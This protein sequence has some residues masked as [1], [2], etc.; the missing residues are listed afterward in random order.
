MISPYHDLPPGAFWRSGVAEAGEP[1]AGSLWPGPVL[2]AGAPIFT[3]GDRLAGALHRGL[4]AAGDRAIEAEPPP[5][6]VPAEVLRAYGWGQ[7]S[8]RTGPLRSPRELAEILGEI[9]G[10]RAPGDVIRTL[11]SGRAADLRRP[12]VEPAGFDSA[13]EA[14]EARTQHLAAIAEGLSGAAA[15]VLCLS[16]ATPLRDPSIRA[17]LPDEARALVP[18]LRAAHRPRPDQALSDLAAVWRDLR[19]LAPEA[20]LLLCLSP[21]TGPRA[22]AEAGAQQAVLRLAMARLAARAGRVSYLP[23]HEL[24]T[25]PG[26]VGRMLGPDGCPTATAID[27]FRRMVFGTLPVPRAADPVMADPETAEPEMA[28]PSDDLACEEALYEAFSP[29][30]QA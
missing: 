14:L 23:L 17:G 3:F 24:F 4:H 1:L 28:E 30:G 19:T 22:G 6:D 26:Q 11:G 2:P 18:G 20:R 21:D 12:G 16:R 9:V 29:R 5:P 10:R 13:E 25:A 7:G 27:G 8:A 15:V